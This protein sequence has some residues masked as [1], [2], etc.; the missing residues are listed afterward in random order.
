MEG[1]REVME[2]CRKEM[3]VAGRTWR[4]GVRVIEAHLCILNL[5]NTQ[6]KMSTGDQS[7]P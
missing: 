6:A 1:Y 3:E 2:G 4:V 7:C 5:R